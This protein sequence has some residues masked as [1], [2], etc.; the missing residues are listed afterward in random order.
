MKKKT[1]NKIF[2]LYKKVQ[3]GDK[4]AIKQFINLY[5]KSFPKGHMI[6]YLEINRK[7][8]LKIMYLHLTR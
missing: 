5:K 4:E 1:D 2:N 7:E 8:A 3:S 6:Q